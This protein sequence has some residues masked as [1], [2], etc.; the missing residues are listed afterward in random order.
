MIGKNRAGFVNDLKTDTLLE[1]YEG[2]AGN[3]RMNLD[4]AEENIIQRSIKNLM[5]RVNKH[6][7]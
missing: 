5:F 4:Y 1:M 3:L 6:N 7:C 2:T